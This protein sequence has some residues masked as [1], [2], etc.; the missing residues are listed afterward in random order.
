[1]PDLMTTKQLS[2]YLQLSERSVYRLLERGA[3][4]GVKVGGQ[5]RFRK[6]VV[7]A[8]LDV[9]AGVLESRELDRLY[10]EMTVPAVTISDLLDPANVV[11]DVAPGSVAEVLASLIA[12]LDFPEEVDRSELHR[13]LVEREALCTTAVA[14]GVALPHTERSGPRLLRRHDVIALGRTTEPVAFGALDGSRTDLLFLVLARDDR[15]HLNL[16][17]RVARLA[18]EPSLLRLLRSSEDTSVIRQQLQEAE[19]A[20]FETAH[21]SM[22]GVTS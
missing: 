18:R 8:W 14:D 11:L 16:L 22:P 21:R 9:Q 2:E 3:V 10:G 5:W 12:G 13:R 6:R 20:V 4:P 19:R 17:A 1:M 7:D 15:S